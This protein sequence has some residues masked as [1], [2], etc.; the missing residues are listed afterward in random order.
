[1]DTKHKM[2]EAYLSLGIETGFEN[3]SLSR[4]T[5]AVGIKKA[6]FYSHFN[7]FSQLEDDSVSYCMEKL[8]ENDFRLNTKAD[9]MR[10]LFEYLFGNLTDLFSDSAVYGLYCMASQKRSYNKKYNDIFTLLENMVNS[11]ILVAL[12]YCVQRSWTNIMDTDSLA[13]LL[14]KSFMNNPDF[15]LYDTAFDLLKK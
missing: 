11:R 2:I 12:D 10:V 15:D 3:I 6:S 14:A 7:S 8:A 5:C 9:N 1:M 13:L 4:I